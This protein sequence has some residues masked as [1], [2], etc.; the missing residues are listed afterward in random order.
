MKLML[1]ALFNAS[2]GFKG[3]G[4]QSSIHPI[5]RSVTPHRTVIS[6]LLR[7][8]SNKQFMGAVTNSS[9]GRYVNTNTHQ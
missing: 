4:I 1:D 8:K 9:T 5:G 3:S 7:V 6:L 2:L